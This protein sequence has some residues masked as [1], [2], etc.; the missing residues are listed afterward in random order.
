LNETV[1]KALKHVRHCIVRGSQQE[2]K[3]NI[4]EH[5]Y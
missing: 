2:H 4:H 3:R 5:E 1:N